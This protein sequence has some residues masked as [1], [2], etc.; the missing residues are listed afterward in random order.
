MSRRHFSWLVVVT[1]L[2]AA[3]VLLMP[4]RTGQ[5]SAIEKSRLLPA[6]EAQVNDLAWLRLV[7][8]GDRTVATLVRAADGWRVEEVQGYAADWERLRAL[9]AG[10][11]QAEVVEAKTANPDYYDRLGVEDVSS[12]GAGGV[13][14]E[15]AADSGLPA[16]ILGDRAQG[17]EGQYVRVAGFAESALVDRAL[18]AP[19][20]TLEWVEREV[21]DVS[22]AEVVEI[23]IVHPDG[24]RVWARKV[25][26]EEEDFTLQGVPEGREPQSAWT[27][28]S[29]AN[30]FSM[31]R[32]DDVRRADGMEWSGSIRYGLVTADGLRLDAELLAVETAAGE[33]EEDP[34]DGEAAHWIRLHASLYQTAVD[35]P[36]TDDAGEQDPAAAAESP[37][38]TEQRA[39]EINRR[40]SGWA[41][42][43]PQYKY[44]SMT[45]RMEALLKDAEA[46]SEG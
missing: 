24:E 29:M 1:L 23:E 37:E 21:V 35:R 36:V 44:D 26:A 41:Y 14:V 16:V 3:A 22:D 31:L 42:R 19:S 18:E 39:Q 43:I 12:P 7:A 6:L 34:V 8:A 45:K 38:S 17:R 27:V 9:L 25:S 28:N 10:L 33:G 2:V 32:L 5:E 15:F 13:R 4:G 20:E 40:V 46:S 11:V 30:G